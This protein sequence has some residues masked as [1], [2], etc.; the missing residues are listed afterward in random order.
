[1]FPSWYFQEPS[2]RQLERLERENGRVEGK[3][4]KGQ[5]SDMIGLFEQ[6][7]PDSIAILKHFKVSTA[8]MNQ[9]LA[10]HEAAMLMRDPEKRSAAEQRP[11]DPDQRDFMSFFGLPVTEGTTHA[12]AK[13]VISI[14][15]AHLEEKDD[16]RLDE[17]RSYESVVEAFDDKEMLAEELEIKRPA[18]SLLRQAI[19]ELK[20]E[21]ITFGTM[22]SEPEVVRDRLLKLKS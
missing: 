8:G 3:P 4:T 6:P 21:G 10:R 20:A 12:V 7:E 2:D 16:P 17:W 18:A 13:R 14:L 1:M 9:T 22:E 11:A 19:E 15:L 5:V